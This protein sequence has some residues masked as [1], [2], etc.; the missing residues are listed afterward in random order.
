MTLCCLGGVSVPSQQGTHGEVP[1]IR[2]KAQR[3]GFVVKYCK[4]QSHICPLQEAGARADFEG[5]GNSQECVLT[6]PRCCPPVLYSGW[7]C[8]DGF[9]SV[10]TLASFQVGMTNFR[11]KAG[12]IRNH[13]SLK[14]KGFKGRETQ[15]EM[16]GLSPSCSPSSALSMSF[17]SYSPFCNMLSQITA[18]G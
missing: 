10:S 12:E 8:T 17:Y 7:F 13:P 1:I 9:C 3:P 14:R 4:I 15:V 2:P 6:S 5:Q 16:E 11:L 18:S